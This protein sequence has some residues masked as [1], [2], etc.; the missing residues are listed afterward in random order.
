VRNLILV[1]MM[2]S[3]KSTVGRRLAAALGRPFID[4]DS[5]LERRCGVPIATIFEL[6]GEVGFRRRESALI[7][8]LVQPA[9]SVLATGGGA[10]IDP[11]SRRL[12]HQHGFVVF[13]EAS[14]AD[15]WQRLR[16]DR[17]RPL[18]A[19]ADPKARIE[20]LLAQRD[21]WY[22][23]AAHLRITTGRQPVSRTVSQIVAQLPADLRVTL[24]AGGSAGEPNAQ[25]KEPW[26][27]S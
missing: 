18:L 17:D 20:A 23:E 4:A 14:L 26:E 21:P 3:G 22:R 15:L 9:G 8:E 11:D 16:R 19:A 5:E 12:M 1:G 24:Q 27:P 7:A 25:S 10:V 2:G 13:L 6:E